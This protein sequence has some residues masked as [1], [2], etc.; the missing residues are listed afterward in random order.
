LTARPA[1][2]L[3]V[4]PGHDDAIAIAFAGRWANLLGVTTVAG[5]VPLALTTRNALV[6]RRLLALD[7]PVHA[8]ADR[9]LSGP[10]R[11]AE[12]IH[13]RSGLDGPTL[14]DDVGE[15]DSNDAVG[16]IVAT[17]RAHPEPVWLIATGPLTNVALAFQTAPDLPGRLAG[18]SLMG[19][20]V[21]RGNVT[22]AAEF[23]VFVDPEAADV[24]FRSGA[25]IVMAGLHLTHQWRVG[26]EHV[27]LLRGL[28]RRAARFCA[29]LLAHYGAA[30]ARA[31]DGPPEGPLHDPLAVLAVTHPHLFTVNARH[32][33]VELAGTHTR[34]MTLADLRPGKSRPQPNVEVLESVD[35]AAATALLL[36]AFAAYA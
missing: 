34:G 23:N 22:A 18:I 24:V 3:D 7:V 32:V 4:D 35:P 19:G 29:E 8:G 33:V 20:S 21:G 26:A 27:A 36:E 13:G 6:L 2:L 12:A 28:D 31:Y 11:T 5:N 17:V 16:F 30:Y 15:S 14:P 10:L 9:P 25:R 1:A